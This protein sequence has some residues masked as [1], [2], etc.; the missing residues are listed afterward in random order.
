MKETSPC[1]KNRKGCNYKKMTEPEI[2]IAK[3]YPASPMAMPRRE[4]ETNAN[5]K[6]QMNQEKNSVNRCESVSK[7]KP[8]TLNVKR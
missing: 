8:Y 1:G 7:T 3:S 6:A 4:Y 2:R 5:F